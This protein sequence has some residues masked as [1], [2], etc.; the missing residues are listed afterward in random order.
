MVLLIFFRFSSV[1]LSID[2]LV[3]YGSI[4]VIWHIQVVLIINPSF[5]ITFVSGDICNN[6]NVLIFQHK[7]ITMNKY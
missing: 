1:A 5:V 2:N 7:Q 4:H 3:F 6:K